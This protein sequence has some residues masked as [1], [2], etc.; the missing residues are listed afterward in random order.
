MSARVLW[1]PWRGVHGERAEV[2][3]KI[4]R[5]ATARV[6]SGRARAARAGATHIIAAWEKVEFN[7]SF[8]Y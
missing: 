2:V 1:R 4:W 7:N 6:S 3:C 8:L 5:A